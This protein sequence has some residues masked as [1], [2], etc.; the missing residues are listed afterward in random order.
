MLL[1]D[2]S[3]RAF[4]LRID[5]ESAS[6]VDAASPFLKLTLSYV[7]E[8]DSRTPAHKL[9]SSSVGSGADFDAMRGRA[10]LRTKHLALNYQ[11]SGGEGAGW[12]YGNRDEVYVRSR[13]ERRKPH[14]NFLAHPLAGTLKTCSCSATR[15][16][17]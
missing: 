13:A 2:K 12:K 5:S 11:S 14:S 4:L 17:P 15:G 16:Y 6:A 9:S 3:H 10:E 8:D 7:D 1:S